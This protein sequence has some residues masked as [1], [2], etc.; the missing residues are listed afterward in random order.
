[1]IICDWGPSAH[2]INDDDDH[3]DDD[4]DDHDHDDHDD[5]E[6]TST[7]TTKVIMR[8]LRVLAQLFD[9][10]KSFL[11][12]YGDQNWVKASDALCKFSGNNLNADVAQ[13]PEPKNQVTLY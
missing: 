3:D 9:V 10:S 12:R 7:M 2:T 5:D 4:H 11:Y 1:M 13:Y 8:L 6:T